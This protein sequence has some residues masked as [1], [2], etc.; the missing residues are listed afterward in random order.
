M[1]ANDR[2]YRPFT[3]YVTML[4]L[5]NVKKWKERVLFHTINTDLCVLVQQA[6]FVSRL[7]QKASVREECGF[8]LCQ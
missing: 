5:P 4:M 2:C 6:E 3:F 7:P 8:P 1:L